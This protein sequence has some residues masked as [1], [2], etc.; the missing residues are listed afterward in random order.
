[1]KPLALLAIVCAAALPVA[2][3]VALP[4]AGTSMVKTFPVTLAASGLTVVGAGGQA[5]QTARFGIVRAAAVKI[6]SAGLGAPTKTGVYPDC[7]QGHAIGYAR[8]RGGIE[9]SFVGGKFVG[10]TLNDGGD[11]NFRTANGVGIG[12]TVAT[13]QRL[14]P[15]VFIDPGNEAEGGLRPSFSSDTGP[16]GWLAGVKPTSKVTSLYAGETCIVS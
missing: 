3:F 16:S 6:A 7:G 12:T 5:A 14:F 13:L 1:M 4:A 15:D 2:T 9:L 11:V 8:F 10:W